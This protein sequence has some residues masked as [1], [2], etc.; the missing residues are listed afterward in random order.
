MTLQGFA[1]SAL[2]R[3]ADGQTASFVLSLGLSGGRPTA[4][5]SD[6]PMGGQG[7]KLPSAVGW[8]GIG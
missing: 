6:T 3:R 5:G 7:W 8:M 2:T 4:G 1:V